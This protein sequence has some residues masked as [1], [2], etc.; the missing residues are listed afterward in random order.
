M[1]TIVAN[2][3]LAA[4]HNGGENSHR[5]PL[6]IS[7]DMEEDWLNPD[8]PGKVIDE[9]LNYQIG[10][11]ELDAWAVSP[12]TGKKAKQGNEIIEKAD[13]GIYNKEIADILKLTA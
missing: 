7:R 4:I 5:M 13:W 6:V 8:T 9:I 12:L 1:F 2:E 10:S 11:K 3:L